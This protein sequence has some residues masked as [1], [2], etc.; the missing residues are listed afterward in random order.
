MTTRAEELKAIV[1]DAWAATDMLADSPQARADAFKLVLEAALANGGAGGQST[2]DT[3]PIA[4]SGCDT[5][6][7]RAAALAAVF[8][9]K[10]EQVG[11]LF[12]LRCAEPALT[13]FA[14]R[15]LPDDCASATREI[16]LLMSVARNAFGLNTGTW[17]LRDLAGTYQRLDLPRFQATLDAMDEVFVRGEP[18]E[19]DRGITLRSL[20]FEAAQAIA[21]RILA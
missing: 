11:D 1:D 10:R 3:A 8:A 14:V 20:G 7:A 13:S 4:I 21:Q 5:P 15:Q 16:T 6:D 12:D 2:D 18:G 9:V 17:L 19:E